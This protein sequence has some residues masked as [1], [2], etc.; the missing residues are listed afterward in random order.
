MKIHIKTY[1]MRN[2]PLGRGVVQI[3]CPIILP[4]SHALESCAKSLKLDYD[5]INDDQEKKV[6]T[7]ATPCP[8]ITEADKILNEM[9]AIVSSDSAQLPSLTELADM[10]KKDLVDLAAKL[11]LDFEGNRQDII[12]RIKLCYNN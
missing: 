11:G 5:V 8:E 3:R 4:Y 10:K 12:S 9:D 7:E 6:N 2:L 1:G